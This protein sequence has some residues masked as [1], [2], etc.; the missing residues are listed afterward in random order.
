MP[1][2]IPG[3]GAPPEMDVDLE[4]ELLPLHIRPFDPA[5]Y[6]PAIH[7]LPPDGLRQFRSFARG[8]QQSFFCASQRRIC[9]TALPRHAISV[10]NHS[11]ALG[12]SHAFRGYGNVVARG[13]YMEL[14]DA[15]RHIVDQA[16][17]GAFCRGLSRLT[18]SRPLLATL[19]ERWWDT[20]DFFHFSAT[21]D[22][23]MTPYDFS[24]LIGIGVGGDPIP[25]DTDM[26]EWDAA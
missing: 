26:D 23:T 20:T 10:L 4:A 25:F 8:S 16:G 21:R 19:V 6:R 9:H 2:D 15:V 12:D 13:W 5:T 11:K 24:M 3:G 18:A 17:F 7:V 22:M 14:P 1:D